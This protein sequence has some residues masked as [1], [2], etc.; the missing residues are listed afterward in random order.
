MTMIINEQIIEFLY[1]FE[2]ISYIYMI[3]KIYVLNF[4]LF[5]LNLHINQSTNHKIITLNE[6]F[7]LYDLFFHRY[8]YF[9]L[10]L[11]QN[12]EKNAKLDI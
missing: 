2:S 10:Y 5:F 4:H 6:I 3:F 8:L 9:I 12:S 1:I 11:I 7:Y